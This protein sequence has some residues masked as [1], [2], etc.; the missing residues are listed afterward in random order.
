[1]KGIPNPAEPHPTLTR[2]SFFALPHPT[3]QPCCQA[4]KLAQ[5]FNSRLCLAG[6]PSFWPSWAKGW[7]AQR[8]DLNSPNPECGI[9]LS[10]GRK[11]AAF[12]CGSILRTPR[13]GLQWRGSDR[14]PSHAAVL[15]VA[16]VCA[17][18]Q[19]CGGRLK[20]ESDGT[21]WPRAITTAVP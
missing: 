21:A 13:R 11:P 18:P 5:V 1:M 6:A 2:T 12:P 16:Q 3:R 17:A 15:S 8:L 10:S 19:R 4:S 20:P 14:A 9:C 7:D